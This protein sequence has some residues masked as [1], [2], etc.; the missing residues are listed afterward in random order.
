MANKNEQRTK[1]LQL[2]SIGFKSYDYSA[3]EPAL[4]N[5]QN[6]SGAFTGIGTKIAWTNP[7]DFE[8]RVNRLYFDCSVSRRCIDI[9][10][11]RVA[12]VPVVLESGNRV[13][14]A[15]FASPNVNDVTLRQFLKVLETNLSL[16]GDAWLFLDQRVSG[17]PQ[18]FL[19][20]Q[21]FIV[22]DALNGVVT[23]DTGN[24]KGQPKPE[25]RFAFTNGRSTKAE[26]F[27]G[28][29]WVEIPGALFHIMEHNPLSSAQGS[30]AGDAVL[31]EVDTWVAANTLINGRF[32]AGGR[33][34]GFI[35]APALQTEQDVAQ[36]KAALQELASA[37]IGDTGVLAGGAEFT[38]N[39]L[40]FTELDVV[41][42]LDAAAR[43]IATGFAVPAV[44]LNL[45][46][47]SSYARDRSVD[48]IYYT[49]WV[50][51]RAQWMVEQLEAHLRRALD[52]TLKLAI[53]DSQLPYFQDDLLEQAKTKAAIGC[54]TVN[55]IRELLSYEPVEGGDELIK[56]PAAAAPEAD[57]SSTD[58]PREVD[59][60]AD[61]SRRPSEKRAANK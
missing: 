1:P 50:K 60:G 58:K 5:P 40:T 36:W 28:K 54:F 42:I 3:T 47:E 24:L 22:H 38:S 39:Q 26:A 31:R 61:T 55:E 6:W 53:D 43:T 8:R 17:T 30:G 41:N 27:I 19:F 34:N 16:G 13:S 35:K 29:R 52:P 4:Q 37:N 2:E 32:Q 49:S 59:F 33:K 56:P 21:D 25:Y 14:K 23:Y 46:G 15:L 20:R 10:A 18:L 7:K 44:M 57:P 9:R 45:A 51:P 11:E 48:R 12:S